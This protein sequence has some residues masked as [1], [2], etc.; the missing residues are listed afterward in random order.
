MKS[1]NNRTGF[2]KEQKCPGSAVYRQLRVVIAGGGTGG[3]LFPGIA[4]AEAFKKRQPQSRILFVTSGKKIEETVLAKTQFEKKMILVEGIKGKG[5]FAK[6]A[7]VCRLPKGLIDAIRLL[8]GFKP[9]VVIGMGAYSAGPVIAAAWMLRTHRVI[10]E[11][12]SL[13]V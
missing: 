8:S 12:N 7:S 9:D 2:G 3:H 13:R 6:L 10:H 5:L 4:I 11:Q 1:H